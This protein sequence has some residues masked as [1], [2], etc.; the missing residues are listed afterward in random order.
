MRKLRRFVCLLLQKNRQVLASNPTQSDT[1]ESI[2]LERRSDPAALKLP[3][4][5][6]EYKWARDEAVLVVE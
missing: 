5:G 6:P 3:T 1:V 4:V 2:V